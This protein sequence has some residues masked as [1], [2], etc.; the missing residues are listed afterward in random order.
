MLPEQTIDYLSKLGAGQHAIAFYEKPEEKWRIVCAHLD[1]NFRNTKPAF[2]ACYFE[3]PDLVRRSLQGQEI[4]I[5]R[6]EKQGSFEI[7]DLGDYVRNERFDRIAE[8][9]AV[10]VDKLARRGTPIRAAGDSTLTVKNGYVDSLLRYERWIGKNLS[11][12]I[13]GLCAYDAKTATEAGDEFFF[14]V[15]KLH[16]HA[17]FPGIA[18]ALA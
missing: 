6:Y 17:L 4:D 7:L 18:L 9:L 10:T 12:P 2:Y 5:D 13:A 11:L 1:Q 8:I 14:E 16:G 3:D 15:L